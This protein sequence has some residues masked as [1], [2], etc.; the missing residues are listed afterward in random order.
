[1]RARVEVGVGARVG[2]RVGVGVGARVEVVARVGVGVG[3]LS[4]A[5]RTC[6]AAWYSAQTS[7]ILASIRG[8]ICAHGYLHAQAEEGQAEAGQAAREVTTTAREGRRHV[9][10]VASRAVSDRGAVPARGR[11]A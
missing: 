5:A 3:T 10:S 4:T 6:V 9:R 11:G 2:A 1:M 7:L 8:I